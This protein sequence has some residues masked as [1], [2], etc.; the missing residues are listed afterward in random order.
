MARTNINQIALTILVVA[1]TGGALFAQENSLPNETPD[2]I[3]ADE[4]ANA[5]GAKY[6]IFSNL[7][8]DPQNRYNPDEFSALPVAG[9]LASGQDERWEA[10]RF[11]PKV[12]VQAKVLSAAIGWISGAKL[13]HLTLYD[14]DELSN[15]P[16]DPLPG[17][18]GSTRN[19][20]KV[21]E[22]CQLATVTLA[23]EGVLLQ[24]GIP[25]WLTATSDDT[26]APTFSGAWHVSNFGN[27]AYF[28][29]PFPWNPQPGTWPA[30]QIRGSRVRTVG[31][32]KETTPE[33]PS[34]EPNSPAATVTIFTNLNRASG[35]D[36]YIVGIGAIIAGDSDTEVKQALPFTPKADVHA[37][38]LSA[39]VARVSG[40]KKINLELYTDAGGVPGAPLPGGQ[41]GTTDFPDSGECCGLATVRLAGGGVALE[42]GVQVWLLASADNT[43]APDFYGIWQDSSSAVA[44]YLEPEIFGFWTSF[45]GLWMAAEVR[46]TRD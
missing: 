36:P 18:D 41:G 29:P 16:R 22:C 5:L 12:D 6:T 42:A 8:S 4:Q 28:Q 7:D 24:A 35:D 19:I 45:S 33:T 39:A 44:A 32:V 17:G 38:I 14:T 34:S 23:G 13:I 10:V 27:S 46:G 11:V 15:A 26:Q 30:A 37:T 40:T 9:R 2:A 25:Y 20:P 21:D 1:L 43:S 31:P 3:A